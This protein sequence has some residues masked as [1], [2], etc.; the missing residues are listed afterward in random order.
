[1]RGALYLR[2]EEVFCSLSDSAP[3]RLH[4]LLGVRQRG[5][6]LLLDGRA[7]TASSVEWGQSRF[8]GVGGRILS[9]VIVERDFDFR[10][11]QTII[12]TQY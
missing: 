3:D 7:L 8:A 12:A 9:E 4:L 2:C 10:F 11:L 5:C 6:D 1:M